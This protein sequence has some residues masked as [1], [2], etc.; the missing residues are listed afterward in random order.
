MVQM[1]NLLKRCLTA[2]PTEYSIPKYFPHFT[3]EIHITGAN[4]PE[5][6]E[7]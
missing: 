4:L 2:H 7:V 6:A 5:A 3:T 1:L